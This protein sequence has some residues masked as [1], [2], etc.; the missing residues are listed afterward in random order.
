MNEESTPIAPP[1]TFPLGTQTQAEIKNS[2]N[3]LVAVMGLTR[4]RVLDEIEKSFEGEDRK[5]AIGHMDEILKQLGD[6]NRANRKVI[7][8]NRRKNNMT[9]SQIVKRRLR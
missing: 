3:I 2:V 9:F 6:G 7:R 1:V 5:F 8:H 4:D